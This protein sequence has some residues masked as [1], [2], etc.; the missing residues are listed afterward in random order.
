MQG[1]KRGR[2]ALTVT[3]VLAA[4]ALLGATVASPAGAGHRAPDQA[5]ILSTIVQ[6]RAALGKSVLAADGLPDGIYLAANS[7][8]PKPGVIDPAMFEDITTGSAGSADTCKA[9]KGWD[10]TTGLGTPHA[11]ALVSELADL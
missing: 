10:W 3:P 5:H 4:A 7:H 2:L 8:E 11:D 6:A 9:K 1:T